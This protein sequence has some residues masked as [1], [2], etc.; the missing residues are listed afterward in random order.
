MENKIVTNY[1]KNGCLVRLKYHNGLVS[2]LMFCHDNKQIWY[3][4]VANEVFLFIRFTPIS[5]K[6]L[7]QHGIRYILSDYIESIT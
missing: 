1:M 7:T 4:Y 6:I 5:A 3:Q 2:R